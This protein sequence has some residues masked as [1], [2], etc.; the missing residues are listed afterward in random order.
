MYEY[1][2]ILAV[3]VFAYSLVAGRV[4]RM[5]LSGPMVYVAFGLV[6]GP[7]LLGILDPGRDGEGLRLLAEL[8]LALVLF[9]DAATANLGVLRR[10]YG[11]P[12]RLLLIGLPLTIAA[13]LGFGGALF[14]ELA[15]LEIAILATMLAPTDAALGAAVVK[16]ESVPSDIREALNVESGLNDGICVPILFVFLALATHGSEQGSAAGLALQLVMQEI[17]IGVA[18]GLGLTFLAS[19]MLTGAM[20]AGW[21]NDVWIQIP[22]VALSLACFAIAQLLGGSGF[23]AAFVG[24]LL[25]GALRPEHRERCLRA[26]E[27]TGE[28]FALLTWVV[29][30]AAVV[31]P[32]LEGLS[33]RVIA[34]AVLSLTAAR[35]VP[36]FV[37]LFGLDVA[38]PGKLFLGWFGPRG[39]ASVVFSIIVIDA[40]LPGGET[41]TSVVV[42]TVTLSIIAHGMTATPLAKAYGK[43]TGAA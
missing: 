37:A 4:A 13:G 27:G 26:S 30:G 6:L 14:P 8:T 25:F 7:S 9:A 38:A 17:G 23:I 22:V 21:V 32:A 20:N 16:N 15:L 24:G 5:A 12:V 34:Y 31:G 3:F 43:A 42:W 40:G 41:I 33:V 1:L 2:A 35:M 36:V 10:T 19:R 29:F 39:L 11:L 28:T 18:V